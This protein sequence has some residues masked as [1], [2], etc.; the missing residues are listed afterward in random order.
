MHLYVDDL[1]GRLVAKTSVNMFTRYMPYAGAQ[2]GA[3]PKKKALPEPPR[4]SLSSPRYRHEGGEEGVG[5]AL[6]L[7]QNIDPTVNPLAGFSHN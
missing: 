7:T 6:L 4:E 2:D 1:F 5:G 3:A